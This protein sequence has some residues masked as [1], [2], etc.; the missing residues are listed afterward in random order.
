MTS[1]EKESIIQNHEEIAE[2]FGVFQ[3]MSERDFLT[4]HLLKKA[5]EEKEKK[6]M[7]KE[8][9]DDEGKE[10]NKV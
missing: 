8:K 6:K 4:F 5:H 2:E 7:K 9:Q 10:G 1:S 3:T